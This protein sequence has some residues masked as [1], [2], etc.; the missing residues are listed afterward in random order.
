MVTTVGPQTENTAFLLKLFISPAH[1][2]PFVRKM[3]FCSSYFQMNR[4]RYFSSCFVLDFTEAG[5]RLHGRHSYNEDSS[6][7]IFGNETLTNVSK[8]IEARLS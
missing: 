1:N 7:T 3:D 5:G 4:H 6:T 2:L 8:A